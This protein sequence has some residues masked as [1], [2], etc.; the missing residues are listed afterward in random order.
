[1]KQIKFV[2]LLASFFI[3]AAAFAQDEQ[4]V[5]SPEWVSDKGYWV[6]ESNVHDAKKCIVYFYNNDGILV[7]KEKVEGLR[8]N[9]NRK[10]TK[11][12]LKQVLESSVVAWEKQ[13]HPQENGSLVVD[14]I[15]KN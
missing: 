2:V 6:V 12:Q 8:I 4:P 15:R 3:K 11:I 10:L 14:K 9:P 13:Q 5:K 1:M 7:Y